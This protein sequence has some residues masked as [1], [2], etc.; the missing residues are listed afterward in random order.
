MPS[1]P[2][3]VR[4]LVESAMVAEGPRPNVVL[5]IDSVGA[6]LGVLAIV[7]GFL[8]LS[9]A[10]KHPEARGKGHAIT[11]IVLGVICVLLWIVGPIV[12][13]ALGY[14]GR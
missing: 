6:I 2:H 11:G 5:E 10:K 9:Y 12:L 1:R 7:F 13:A 8:G 14:F 4:M 3:S